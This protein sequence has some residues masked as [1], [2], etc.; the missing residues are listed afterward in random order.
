[1]NTTIRFVYLVLGFA[2][3][4]FATNYII[5][6]FPAVNPSGVLFITVPVMILFFLTRRPY[7]VERE[8][9]KV[10]AYHEV[11]CEE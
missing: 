9:K 7:T 8:A 4:V 11:H 5:T 2:G 1:M 6:T 3:L 10:R